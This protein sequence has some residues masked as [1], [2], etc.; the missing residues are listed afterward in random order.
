M[1]VDAEVTARLGSY[2][3]SKDSLHDG[4]NVLASD[5]QSRWRLLDDSLWTPW[6]QAG[7]LDPA[8]AVL[9][10]LFDQPRWLDPSY[11]YDESGSALFEE[12][13]QLP[14]YYLTRLEDGI[15]QQE[16]V[17]IIAAAP[18]ECLVELGAGFSK[19]TR[20]L[21]RAQLTRRG[22]GIFAPVDVSPSAL[23][24]SRDAQRRAFPE[25]QFQ[26]LVARYEDGIAGIADDLPTLF[27]F[28]GSTVGNF[29]RVQFGQFFQQLSCSM[30]PN[31]FLLLGVDEVKEAEIVERAY[32][33]SQGLTADFVLNAF[34]HVNQLTGSNF[35]RARMEYAPSYNSRKQQME[36][37]ALATA[38]QEIRFPT[39]AASFVW[40]ESEP[41]LLEISRK[42]DVV[43]LL[44]QLQFFGLE[45]VERYTDDRQWFS[46]LLLRRSE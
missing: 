9:R 45:L 13:S 43:S 10:T 36:M 4:P 22:L 26:G 1:S 16:A 30:G 15:L 39:V 11:L 41:I 46:V 27:I 31:D 17:N 44:S 24:G 29:T 7:K 33:D 8:L 12:I 42:F 32:N 21:L 28:L 3:I 6:E 2:G 35:D 37:Y 14:E 19:K 5:Q 20:H 34:N 40:R 18:V 38:S 23:S 25:I